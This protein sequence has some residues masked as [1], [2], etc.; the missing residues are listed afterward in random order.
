VGGKGDAE[1]IDK[2]IEA[3]KVELSQTDDMQECVKI[4]E[5]ITRLASGIAVI[6]VGG[7]TEVEMIE[8]RHRIE[9]ALEAVRS[10]QEEGILPGGGVALVR[11]IIDLDVMVDNDEQEIGVKIIKEAIKEPARQI[12]INAGLSPD[13]TLRTIEGESDNYGIDYTTNKVVDM[14]EEGIIDPAKVEI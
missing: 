13:L 11:S 5:R 1:E 6:K 4:Q 8:K 2:K 7:A 3:L 10:A 14:Y 9:D 12:A